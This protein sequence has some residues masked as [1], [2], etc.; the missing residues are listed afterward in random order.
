MKDILSVAK[1]VDEY[2]M[3]FPE[4]TQEILD[5]IRATIKASAPDAEELISYQMPSYKFKGIL[6]Y[7]AAYKKHIGFYPTGAGVSAFMDKLSA[8]KV[9]KG[10][11]QFHLDKPIPVD[12]IAEIVKFRV[13]ENLEK[14]KNK[15]NQT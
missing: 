10:T 15:I 8:Y 2:I 9:S 6:V 3:G 1:N 7:F 12:L 5:Q 11:I 13:A 14:S 4:K